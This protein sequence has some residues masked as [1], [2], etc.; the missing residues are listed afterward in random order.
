MWT[1]MY[2]F[3]LSLWETLSGKLDISGPPIN[4]LA[5]VWIGLYVAPT[6]GPNPNA[7]MSDITEP[8]FNG[9]GRQEV[10]WYPPYIDISGVAQLEGVSQIY[11]PTD[12]LTQTQ[13]TGLF[14][15]TAPVGG[16]LLA[17]QP[18]GGGG[19]PLNTTLQA[20]VLVPSISLDPAGSYG[21]VDIAP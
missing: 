1:V 20:L 14:L 12:N 18:I 8:T 3:L 6:P 11:R 19:Y 4:P 5:S 10:V 17:M 7:T 21:G 9:Y 15:A 13:I 16:T 2:S